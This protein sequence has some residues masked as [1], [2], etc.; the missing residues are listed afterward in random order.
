MFTFD[1]LFFSADQAYLAFKQMF[2]DAKIPSEPVVEVTDGS[3]PE[4]MPL[5]KAWWTA[6]DTSLVGDVSDDDLK[7]DR[8]SAVIFT[9]AL[10]DDGYFALAD[11]LE[12]HCA[13]LLK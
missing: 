5:I 1:P 3:V 6:L 9:G 2:E 11:E 10:R 7:R 4:Y 8:E 12:M 13:E